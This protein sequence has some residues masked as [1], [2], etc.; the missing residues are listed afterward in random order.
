ML[1]KF[2]NETSSYE[3]VKFKQP[4]T[5]FITVNQMNVDE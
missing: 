5:V 2:P 3:M 4:G 1:K